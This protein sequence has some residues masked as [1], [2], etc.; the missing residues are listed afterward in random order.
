[1]VLYNALKVLEPAET[2]TSVPSSPTAHPCT[3]S[4]PREAADTLLSLLAKSA[5]KI[6]VALSLYYQ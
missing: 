1:M 5:R 2:Q 4:T 6:L 3:A